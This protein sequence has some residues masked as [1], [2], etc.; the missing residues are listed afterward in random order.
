M[1]IPSDGGSAAMACR[2]GTSAPSPV[3]PPTRP[4]EEEW[5]VETLSDLGRRAEGIIATRP[6]PSGPWC[7]ARSKTSHPAP[8]RPGHAAGGDAAVFP[9]IR[10]RADDHRPVGRQFRGA[11]RLPYSQT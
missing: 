2:T 11:H 5:G 8:A 6:S 3:L 4:L 7:R 10:G 9:A 1:V